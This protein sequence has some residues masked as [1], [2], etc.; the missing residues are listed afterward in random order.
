M[1]SQL[2]LD[3]VALP[4]KDL[5]HCL[6]FLVDPVLLLNMQGMATIK[7][8]FFFKKNKWLVWFIFAYFLSYFSP[9]DG[10]KGLVEFLCQ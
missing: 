3:E 1:D 10:L 5:I 6:R 7:S 2:V 8:C 4:L 9:A